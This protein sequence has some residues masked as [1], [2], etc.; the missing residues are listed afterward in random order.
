[1]KIPVTCKCDEHSKVEIHLACEYCEGVG[2]IPV[3]EFDPDS[4]RWMAGVGEQ[5]CICKLE[6]DVEADL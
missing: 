5:R 2:Y 1:M 4:G 3:D 6:A